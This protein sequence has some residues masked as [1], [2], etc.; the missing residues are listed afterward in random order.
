MKPSR[1]GDG[2]GFRELDSA[3]KYLNAVIR[4]NVLQ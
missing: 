3:E 4:I 2:V 1:P